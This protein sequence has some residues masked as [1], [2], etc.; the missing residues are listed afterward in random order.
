M[1]RIFGYIGSAKLD[2]EHLQKV[3]REQL[4]GGPD[5][6][7]FCIRENWSLGSN[8]LAIQGIDGGAQPYHLD[9][10]TCVFNGEI[11]NHKALRTS[12]KRY[13]YNFS[14]HCDGN[15]ILPLYQHYGD[16]FVRLLEG[17][18]AI[19]I[20][21]EIEGRSVLKLL[22]DYSGMKSLYYTYDKAYSTAHFSSELDA[23]Q[24]FPGISSDIRIE[25]IDQF[26]GGKAI[27]GPATLYKDVYTLAPGSM[28]TFSP[29]RKPKLQLNDIPE[30]GIHSENVDELE[31]YLHYLLSRE[32]KL[33]LSADVPVSVIT[34]GGLDSSYITSIAS[35]LTDELHS[36]NISYRG[37]WPKDERH[38]ANTV[39]KYCH[40]I[41]HQ[42]ELDPTAL[43]S[44]VDKFVAALDQPNTAPHS[45]STFALFEGVHQAGFKVA[46][47]GDGADELFCGYRR[48]ITAST[49]KSTDWYKNYQ[50]SMAIAG[51][52][53]LSTLY[54]AEMKQVL[55]DSYFVDVLGNTL[56]EKVNQHTHS[57]LETLLRFDQRSRFPYYILR[58]VDHLSMAHSVEAR[59]PFL[60][61]RIVRLSQVL[62]SAQKHNGEIGK[63]PV[64]KAASGLLP[65]QII[66]RKKQPFTL[67]ITSMIKKGEAIY[68]FIEGT[69]LSS[70]TATMHL[71]NKKEIERL[72]DLK[73][74]V[75]N[76][77]VANTLWSLMI[78]ERWMQH[79]NLSA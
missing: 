36:F 79:R 37:D 47:T 49:D 59:M 33:M 28:L 70:H 13:G 51:S 1:C 60:Q 41:H 26:F 27:W 31:H 18:F 5:A 67:P 7:T 38:F 69:L 12:L 46:L 52:D 66:E 17:M 22:N 50:L 29:G 39:A 48:F 10:L 8:R 35:K 63:T 34:S 23:L 62:T 9:K 77:I 78:L 25:A 44:Y 57:K 14:D 73:S 30:F 58:R 45:L 72:I 2:K 40:T 68:E 19:A 54:S 42:I 61:P 74:D 53:F 11:Y 32:I 71:F 76:S 43:P 3:S 55:Q 64:I 20:V 75:P 15:I 4:S 21:D 16:E 6:Q 24:L 56:N 65:D